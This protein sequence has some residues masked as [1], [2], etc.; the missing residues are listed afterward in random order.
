M[1]PFM[2]GE[3]SDESFPK[4]SESNGILLGF[5]KQGTNLERKE[6]S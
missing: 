4:K 5:K 3:S 2:F 1:K 6:G